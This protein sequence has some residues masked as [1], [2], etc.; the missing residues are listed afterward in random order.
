MTRRKPACPPL[1]P[2]QANN[3]W[4][5]RRGEGSRPFWKLRAYDFNVTTERAFRVKLDYIHKNPITRGLVEHPEQWPW[6]SYRYY[7]LND[8]SLLEMDWNGSWPIV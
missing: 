7:E 2:K 1:G 8:T 5:F 3:D 4:F 6:G